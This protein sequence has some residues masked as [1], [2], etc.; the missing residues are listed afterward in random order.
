MMMM[1]MMMMMMYN[2][3]MYVDLL[4]HPQEPFKGAVQWSVFQNR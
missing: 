2:N 3:N 1:M 4:K